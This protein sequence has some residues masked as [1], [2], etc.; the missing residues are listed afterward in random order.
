LHITV[1]VGSPFESKV[2]TLKLLFGAFLKAWYL[3]IKI[4]VGGLFESK[5]FYIRPAVTVGG[6]F[7]IK[8]LADYNCCW[9]A[10]VKASHLHITFAV[11]GPF[12]SRVLTHYSFLKGPLQ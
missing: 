3:H 11:D 10:S 4:I 5:E 6:P 2:F 1:A 12:E 9:G 7:E 8:V